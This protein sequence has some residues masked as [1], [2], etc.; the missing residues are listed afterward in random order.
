MML[1]ILKMNLF[2]LEKKEDYVLIQFNNML[3][4]REINK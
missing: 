2:P 3:R 1:N 4:A